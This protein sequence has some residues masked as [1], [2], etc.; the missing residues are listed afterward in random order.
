MTK[1]EGGTE[2]DSVKHGHECVRIGHG[3]EF[4][5]ILPAMETPDRF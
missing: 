2:E 5:F 3:E 4:D 1:G